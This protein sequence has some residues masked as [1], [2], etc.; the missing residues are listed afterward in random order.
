MNKTKLNARQ[1]QKIQDE[2][3]QDKSRQDYKRLPQDKT[4]Q[5]QGNT[6]T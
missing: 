1:D 6:I 2:T 4:R 3:K 5:P